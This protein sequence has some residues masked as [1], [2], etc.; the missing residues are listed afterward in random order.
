LV[1]LL[2]A[3]ASIRFAG[4]AG[5][6]VSTGGAAVTPIKHL[7]VIFQENESFDHYFG[8]YPNATNPAGEPAFTA[9]SGTPTIDG[10]TTR[11]L[12][13]NPNLHQPFRVDRLQG[14]SCFENG[15][16][17]AEQVMVN[18]G[19]MDKFVQEFK[20]TGGLAKTDRA[21]CPVDANGNNYSTMG[22]FDGNAVTALWNYAQNFAM[23]DANF[24][25]TF[26]PST[27]GAIN[28]VAATNGSVLCGPASGVYGSVPPCLT[29]GVPPFDNTAKPAPSTDQRGTL[30]TDQD[31][32]WDICSST[33]GSL[34]AMQGP[35][36]G[37]LLNKAGITWGWFEGGFTPDAQ[38]KCST[39]A[40][41]P[42]ALDIATGLDPASDP[43]SQKDYIPHHEPFQFFA[44]TANPQHLPPSSLAMIGKADQANHQYDIS[45]FWDAL[46][47]GYL[48]AVSFIKAP[49]YQD[50][51][52]GY[53]DP[54]DEQQFLVS[55]INRLEQSKDWAST[56]VVI[57]YDDS[58]GYYDH[59]HAPIVNNSGT[60]LDRNCG[61]FNDDPPARCGYGPRLPL[62]VISPFARKN[63]VS[64]ATHDQTSSVRFIEDNWLSGQRLGDT[65]FD[66]MA[67]SLND[68]FDYSA[69][70]TSPLTLDPTTG[71]P[72][73]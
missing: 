26:G 22:Y 27:V 64:H 14:L 5:A 69:Q 9:A 41:P 12:T 59:V 65:T 10:Y 11:L 16:Y 53:S 67:G 21:F 50:S 68:L 52:A 24:D 48:P 63:F 1:L 60:P 23:S 49:G 13:K 57:T 4:P 35:N 56:A 43:F 6:G 2:V 72:A 70:P 58:N 71:L 37:D 8:T 38:G 29:A 3:T 33:D 30:Y 45:S 39:Q 15:G 17:D 66:Q 61:G 28:L 32:L 19:G 44:S 34:V 7:V 62:L 40:H 46:D 73:H 18:N 47:S 54:L 36:I 51:H 20:Y 25:T 42:V 55:T 31:P